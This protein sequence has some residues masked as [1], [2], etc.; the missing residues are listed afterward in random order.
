MDQIELKRGADHRAIELPRTTGPIFD[1]S[2]EQ[3]HAVLEEWRRDG[4]ATA[5]APA[6]PELVSAGKKGGE[7]AAPKRAAKRPSKKK[8]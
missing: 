4:V 8:H 7:R 2:F 3:A 1:A 5:P 6:E